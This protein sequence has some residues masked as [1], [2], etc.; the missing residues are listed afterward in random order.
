MPVNVTFA[1]LLAVLGDVRPGDVVPY[2]AHLDVLVDAPEV[3]EI[4]L[5]VKRSGKVPV[6]AVP[7]VRVDGISWESLGLDRADAVIALAIDNPNTFKMD[8]AV[9]DLALELGGH[10]IVESIAGKSVGV[11]PGKSRTIEI[12]ISFAPKDLGLAAF[13]MLTGGGSSYRLTG[14]LKVDTPFGPIAMPYDKAGQV[15]FGG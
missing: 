12:P 11:G 9:P 2:T 15:A 3:G 14:D 13:N 6:P 7:S 4:S 1:D 10:R 5:P 8:V